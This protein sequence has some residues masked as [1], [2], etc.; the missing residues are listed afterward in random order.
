M[1][2]LLFDIE[3]DK[4]ARRLE[5]PEAAVISCSIALDGEHIASWLVG[6]G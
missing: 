6:T 1:Q 5:S 4:L 2:R 3:L